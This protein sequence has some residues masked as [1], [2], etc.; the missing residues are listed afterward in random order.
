MSSLTE[1]QG[2]NIAR[3]AGII[4]GAPAVTGVAD[5][6]TGAIDDVAAS[7]ASDRHV[8]VVLGAPFELDPQ[9][10]QTIGDKLA[11]TGTRLHVIQARSA[12]ADRLQELAHK[13]HGQTPGGE[14]VAAIDDVRQ[15]SPTA[16][17]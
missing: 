17:G 12:T 8:I 13:S 6:I 1:D 3:I 16:T 7:K 5:L 15:R 14:I 10:R 11:H 4:A 2:A 9:A